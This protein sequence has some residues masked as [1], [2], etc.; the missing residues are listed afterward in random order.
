MTRKC[1][2]FSIKGGCGKTTVTISLARALKNK[3]LKIG[4]MD[5]DITGPKL[6]VALGIPKPFSLPLVD[7]AR[8]KMFP[9]RFD[10]F[11]VFSEA[12]ALNDDSAF[13]WNGGDQVVE[14]FGEKFIL[15]GTGLY[16][17][18]EQDLKTIEFSADLDYILYDMPTCSSD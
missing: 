18:V 4:M 15:P 13:M 11:E 1:T 7:V 14:A 3:G 6:P 5:I 12:F 2:V 16:S 10:G 9:M 8:G 17:R